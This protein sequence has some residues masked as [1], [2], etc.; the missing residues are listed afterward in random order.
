[1]DRGRLVFNRRSR[2]CRLCLLESFENLIRFCILSYEKEDI[3]RYSDGKVCPIVI[4][5]PKKFF[6]KIKSVF[7]HYFRKLND[8]NPKWDDLRSKFK[9]KFLVS[10]GV[11]IGNRTP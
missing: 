5:N 6:G 1:M 2:N 7:E 9:T 3:T 11:D 8:P 10:Y 4:I